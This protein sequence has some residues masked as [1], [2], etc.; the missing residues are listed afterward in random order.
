ME[1][2]ISEEQARVPV[3]VFSVE[4]A[5]A[6]ES[7]A[8]LQKQAEDAYEAGTRYLLLD[9][10]KVSFVSSSGL[11]AIH[12]IFM[13]L[14]VH[15]SEEEQKAVQ[16]GVRQGTYKS[17]YLK[18]VTASRDVQKVLKMSGFDMF[19]GIYSDRQEAIASF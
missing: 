9:M 6:A 12:Q 18:L 4:G 16:E 11:R 5:I 3:T 8:Q 14:S 17:P 7:Y 10:S 1:I 15:G 19:L 13:M 2:S